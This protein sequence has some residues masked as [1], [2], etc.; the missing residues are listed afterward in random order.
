MSQGHRLRKLERK[1][2]SSNCEI[3]KVQEK[4]VVL[5]SLLGAH[6]KSAVRI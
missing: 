2:V 4:L 1:G 3:V 5:P 6:M